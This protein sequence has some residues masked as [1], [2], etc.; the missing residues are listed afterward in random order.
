M[1]SRLS[2]LV[3]SIYMYAQNLVYRSP[4]S[5]PYTFVQTVRLLKKKKHK[6]N[7]FLFYLFVYYAA[8]L[9]RRG[10]H[11]TSHSVCPSVCRSVPLLL[12]SVT[13]RHLANYNDTHVLFGKGRI[14]Y[15]HLGRT[16]S[17]SVGEVNF[18]LLPRSPRPLP[19]VPPPPLPRHHHHHYYQH[20]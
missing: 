10:P 17:C 16:N 5:H 14:S 9:P 15:G 19:S 13:S 12:L 3:L 4:S 7:D 8:L 6:D 20:R 18:I 1:A 2:R 11:I